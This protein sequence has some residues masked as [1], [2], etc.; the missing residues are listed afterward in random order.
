MRVS[1]TRRAA[2]L[3][4]VLAALGAQVPPAA[5]ATAHGHHGHP[6]R[7]AGAPHGHATRAC[8]ARRIAASGA[9]RLHRAHLPSAGPTTAAPQPAPTAQG[10]T[11]PAT[12]GAPPTTATQPVNPAPPQ[13]AMPPAST[14]PVYW[15]AWIG[16]SLT[17]TEAPW[18]A[19]AITAFGRDAGKAPSLVNFSSPFANCYASP[20]TTYAFPAAEF[21]TIRGQGAI[22]FFSW[23][24]DALPLSGD[25]SAYRLSTIAAGGQDA[26]ITAWATAARDWGHPFFLRFNWEMNGNWFPWSPG[27]NGNSAADFVAAWRHVHD[28]FTRVGATNVTW[29]W[30][31]NIDPDSVLTPLSSVYPGDAYVDWTALDGYNWN[32]PWT[33][34]AAL[35][36]ATYDRITNAIAPSK[37]ML[38]GETASTETGGSK[39]QWITDM[40]Q[41][42]ATRFPRIRGLLWFD[43]LDDGMDWPIE[44][45]ASATAAFRAGVADPR[46]VA[47]TAAALPPGPIAPPGG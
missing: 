11:T 5:Q 39:A 35:F 32:T 36:G 46:Y 29:V 3:G 19:G 37:P 42:L 20:C 27:K 2:L 25:Q 28:I 40:F 44:T 21:D 33:S 17:G 16:S 45:S 30:C 6:V 12:T 14:L 41:S 34:F 8:A 43:K 18:D 23:A 24:T 31:P 26:Y 13:A 9:Q 22:P 7:C 1:G 15:G 38:V 10:T 4:A 47:N